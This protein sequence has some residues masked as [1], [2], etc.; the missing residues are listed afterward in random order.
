MTTKLT[1]PIR[2]GIIGVGRFGRLHARAAQSLFGVELAA[3]CNRNRERLEAASADLGVDCLYEDYRQLLDDPTIDA[4]SITTHVRDHYDIALAALA[5]GTHVLLEK[6]MASSSSECGDI[7]EAAAAAQG[8]FMVGHICRFDPRVSLAKQAIDEGRIGRVVSMHAKRN[9]P[10]A[11]GW[12]RL[13]KTSPLMGDGI[14]DS[15]LMMWFM[16][17][18]PSRVYARYVRFNDFTYPDVGWAMLEFGDDAIGVVETNWGL[19]ENT[20]TVIDARLEVVGTA[21]MLTVDC[22]QT[23]LSVLDSKGLKMQDTDYWPEQFGSLVGTLRDELSYFAHCIREDLTP[24]VITPFEAA[25]AVSIVEAAEQ[26]AQLR[27]PVE[28]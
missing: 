14:H 23:G 11:P 3:L 5:S 15:D 22:S 13:D 12:L 28:L 4:V 1:E 25:R 27:Q 16:D 9:L 19:P 2:W 10:V 26:S 18:A 7:V 8:K 20:P 21:G 17:A 24:N 6:P